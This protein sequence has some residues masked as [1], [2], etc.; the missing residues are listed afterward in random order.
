MYC[1]ELK[2]S[3]ILKI[4]K[5]GCLGALQLKDNKQENLKTL[6]KKEKLNYRLV[7]LVK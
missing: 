7:G 6:F 4:L 3:K 2:S 1:G 5:C